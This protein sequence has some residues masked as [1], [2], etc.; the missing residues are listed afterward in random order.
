MASVRESRTP[1][2]G[3]PPPGSSN[4]KRVP[5]VH[6]PGEQ[7]SAVWSRRGVVYWTQPHRRGEVRLASAAVGQ[8]MSVH[9]ESRSDI[10]PWASVL[11][12]VSAPCSSARRSSHAAH[13]LW[14]PA[15]AP[16]LHC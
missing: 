10:E 5:H 9:E 1:C 15:Y 2:C 8:S 13:G 14:T 3:R 12:G 16:R 7:L 6:G 4:L 11:V